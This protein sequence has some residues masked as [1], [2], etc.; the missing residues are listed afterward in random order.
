MLNEQV[1]TEEI[2]KI[3]NNEV[4]K[5][6]K[7]EFKKFLAAELKNGSAKDDI[8]DVVK[9]ALNNLYKFMWTKRN[10]W[11]SELK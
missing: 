7:N 3:V 11:N 9:A 10:M 6:F 8:Q 1:T 4:K 5:A 2:K